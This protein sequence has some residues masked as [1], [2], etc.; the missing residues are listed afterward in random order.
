ME[1]IPPA[2]A[3]RQKRSG[4]RRWIGKIP[5]RRAWQA[6]PVVLPGEFHG[7]RSLGGYSPQGHT[8]SDTTEV[9]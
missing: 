3:S 8:E 1:K 2:N 7:Q 6:T 9:T 5:W 4:F